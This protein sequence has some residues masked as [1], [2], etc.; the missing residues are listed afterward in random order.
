MLFAQVTD[1][2]PP[3]HLIIST[4][5]IMSQTYCM[6]PVACFCNCWFAQMKIALTMSYDPLFYLIIFALS[7]YVPLLLLSVAVGSPR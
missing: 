2:R 4:L 6:L 5:T 7:L 3:V 1:L